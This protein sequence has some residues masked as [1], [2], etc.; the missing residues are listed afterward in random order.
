MPGPDRR[1]CSSPAPVTEPSGAGRATTTRTRAVTRGQPPDGQFPAGARAGIGAG[2]G[3]RTGIHVL[4]QRPLREARH[5]A[6]QLSA[7]NGSMA[8]VPVRRTG[9]VTGRG[10]LAST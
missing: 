3:T 7:K 2:E 6:A 1:R 10:G 8:G 4:P 9:A 5:L